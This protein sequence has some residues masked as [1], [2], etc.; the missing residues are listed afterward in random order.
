M[1][2]KVRLLELGYEVFESMTPMEI[3]LVIRCRDG[4]SKIQVKKVGFIKRKGKHVKAMHLLRGCQGRK[5]K[6]YMASEI[7]FFI[8][9]DGV[10]FHIVPFRLCSQDGMQ[11]NSVFR[12][13]SETLNRFDL[14]PDPYSAQLAVVPDT[15]LR[16]I[17]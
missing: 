7:D 11:S 2:V 1:K 15:Q 10:N 12:V 3:D 13:R 4:F 17:A 16:L 5:Y 8:G 14:L 9:V 6:R